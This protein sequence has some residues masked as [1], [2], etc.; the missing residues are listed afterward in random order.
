MDNK[1]F[2]LWYLNNYRDNLKEALIVNKEAG[3]DFYKVKVNVCREKNIYE[4]YLNISNFSRAVLYG[5]TGSGKTYVLESVLKNILFRTKKHCIYLNLKEYNG[6]NLFKLVAKEIKY[7]DISQEILQQG[8]DEGNIVFIFDNYHLLSSDNK[9]R[10]RNYIFNNKELKNIQFLMS[11]N[12]KIDD[13]IFNEEYDIKS[14]SIKKVLKKIIVNYCKDSF[15]CKNLKSHI[16]KYKLQSFLYKPVNL[17]Y[18][19]ALAEYEQDISF[20]YKLK[21]EFD[22]YKSYMKFLAEDEDI[23]KVSSYIAYFMQRK[24]DGKIQGDFLRNLVAEAVRNFSIKKDPDEILKSIKETVMIKSNIGGNIYFFE[25]YN[26][27]MY[28]L[29]EYII[30]NGI[31]IKDIILNRKFQCFLKWL[32]SLDAKFTYKNLEYLDDRFI[33]NMLLE[34]ED[35]KV[36]EFYEYILLFFKD[37]VYDELMYKLNFIYQRFRWEDRIQKLTLEFLKSSEFEGKSKEALLQ[38]RVVKYICVNENEKDCYKI[39]KS[40]WKEESENSDVIKTIYIKVLGEGNK[41]KTSDLN[42]SLWRRV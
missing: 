20:I 31:K 40:L 1:V 42:K 6:E 25:D 8:I 30:Q 3:F 23:I 16:E 17:S 18:L 29:Y 39:L 28:L 11:S 24:T 2:T 27:N 41:V 4:H 12:E 10:I 9:R 33:K 15:E 5:S 22:L 19:L 38:N 36:D 32:C 35:R 37:K 13:I 26:L 21:N 14:L 7:K 34:V